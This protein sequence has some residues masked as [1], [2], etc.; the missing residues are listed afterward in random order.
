MKIMAHQDYSPEEKRYYDIKR[1]FKEAQCTAG[2]RSDGRCLAC[3][4]LYQRGE[5]IECG[6]RGE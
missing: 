4:G 1:I 3:G 5:C 6:H 2:A